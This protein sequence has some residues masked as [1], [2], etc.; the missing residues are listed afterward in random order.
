M[1]QLRRPSGQG[2]RGRPPGRGGEAPPEGGSAAP[3]VPRRAG[4]AMAGDQGRLSLPA[5]L[6]SAGG[7]PPREGAG[8]GGRVVR[9]RSR[10]ERNLGGPSAARPSVVGFCLLLSFLPEPGALGCAASRRR[11]AFAVLAG[12]GSRSP[13]LPGAGLPCPAPGGGWPSGGHAGGRHRELA[14]RLLRTLIAPNEGPDT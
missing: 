13:P 1:Y 4:E 7:Q 6:G 10:R 9:S 11:G 2:P 14:A 12:G 5:V 3:A 8:S